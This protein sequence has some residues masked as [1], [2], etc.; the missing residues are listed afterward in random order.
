EFA[1]AQAT[2]VKQFENRNVTREQ[3]RFGI[4]GG[5][6]LIDLRAAQN[7]RQ[8]ALGLWPL[9]LLK[10]VQNIVSLGDEKSQQY[11][12]RRDAT[13]N[14]FGRLTG[15][16]LVLKVFAVVVGAGPGDRFSS[17][18]QIAIEVFDV[19]SISVKRVLG[20]ASFRGEMKQQRAQ[21]RLFA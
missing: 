12:N 5:D 13:R 21:R 10:D 2:G 16:G 18:A 19:S 17:L 9:A 14:G 4:G 20:Q 15:A 11:S 3:R 6:E 8:R 1:G 7:F